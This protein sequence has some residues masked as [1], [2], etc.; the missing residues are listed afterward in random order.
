[1]NTVSLLLGRSVLD[2]ILFARLVCK[3]RSLTLRVNGRRK[4]VE[5]FCRWRVLV[6]VK[7]LGL[8]SVRRTF[9][10]TEWYVTKIQDF[11]FFRILIKSDWEWVV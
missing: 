8:R 7:F 4:S 11:F 2:K 10:F 1:M 3:C 6:V 9:V 5:R